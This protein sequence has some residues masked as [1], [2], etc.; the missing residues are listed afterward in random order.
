V[1][2]G[3]HLTFNQFLH[4]RESLNDAPMR[5]I[6]SVHTGSTDKIEVVSKDMGAN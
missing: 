5:K 6:E 1:S 3:A 2:T 4:A